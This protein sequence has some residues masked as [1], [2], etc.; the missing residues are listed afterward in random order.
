MAA[1][2]N[3]G[4]SRG[5]A[6]LIRLA[7]ILQ[8]PIVPT[9]DARAADFTVTTTMDCLGCGSLRD[10]IIGANAATPIAGGH[11]INFAVSGTTTLSYML[12]PIFASL[13]IN[14]PGTGNLTI[15]GANSQR[16]F[17]I[18]DGSNAVNV[19][20]KNLSVTNARAQG[21]NA[22]VAGGGGLGAGGALFVNSSASVMVHNVAFVNNVAA[23]GAGGSGGTGNSG[24][25]GGGMGGN[26]GL[27]FAAGGGGLASNVVLDPMI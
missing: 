27:G 10:A 1:A 7:L 9:Q 22:S 13:S 24:G 3:V 25:G 16:V 6:R 21:G 15:S 23:G 11:T 4:T 14:G 18:G 2:C 12:P 5:T 20:I 26:A 19:A 17:F 8:L